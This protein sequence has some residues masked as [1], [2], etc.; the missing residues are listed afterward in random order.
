MGR[1][2]IIQRRRHAPP[3]GGVAG[4][5]RNGWPD[6]SGMGGRNGSE[7]VAGMRRNTQ[8]A[9]QSEGEPGKAGALTLPFSDFP[10]FMKL[11]SQSRKSKWPT[12]IILAPLKINNLQ[13]TE[14]RK[15]PRIK[16][17]R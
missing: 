17:F 9:W 10:N 15:M 11:L 2:L 1:G 12:L 8:S 14:N 16:V 4:M 3:L 13:A 6:C 7:W 5:L